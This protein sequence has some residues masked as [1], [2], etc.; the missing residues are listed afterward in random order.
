MVQIDL[1][2]IN[3]AKL[4]FDV[5]GHYARADLFELKTNGPK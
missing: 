3:A 1:G 2:F 4:D 5:V